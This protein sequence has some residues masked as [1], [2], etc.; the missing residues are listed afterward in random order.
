MWRQSCREKRG[1][2]LGR[3]LRQRTQGEPHCPCMTRSRMGAAA[4]A[5]HE[6]PRALVRPSLR[7]KAWFCPRTAR[8]HNRRT[9]CVCRLPG[10]WK[11]TIPARAHDAIPCLP[12]PH[13]CD[14]P[15]IRVWVVGHAR[16]S[17]ASSATLCR[18]S[19]CHCV[20]PGPCIKWRATC[21]A[22][23]RA[24]GSPAPHATHIRRRSC[25]NTRGAGQAACVAVVVVVAVAAV[26]VDRAGVTG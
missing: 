4:T 20:C 12:L 9:A 11:S 15:C 16:Q 7:P 19:M 26:C 13:S 25:A 5:E 23:L 24:A 10:G 21:C 18:C 1:I 22:P 6:I 14:A 2:S 8:R 17:C 3:A